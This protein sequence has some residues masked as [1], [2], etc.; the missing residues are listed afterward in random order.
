MLGSASLKYSMIESDH[1]GF[2]TNIVELSTDPSII[3]AS[4]G[5]N[6]TETYNFV[7]SMT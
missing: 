7:E 3:L 6:V 4:F 5:V 2:T 1:L